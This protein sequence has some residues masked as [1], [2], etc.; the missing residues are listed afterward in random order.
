[1]DKII[2]THLHPDIDALTSI[3]LI[4]RFLPDWS[5]AKVQLVPPGETF[6]GAPPDDDPDVLH[7]D[8]GMGKLDHHKKR[9][10]TSA[11]ELTLKY[12]L[13][14]RDIRKLDKQALK[15]M[16]KVVN[17]IDNG[18]D[19]GWPDASSDHYE[20]MFH[21]L[22]LSSHQSQAEERDFALYL[23]ILDRVFQLMKSKVQ[24]EK[25]LA[26]KGIIFETKWGKG[27][28]V[29]SPNDQ[30]IYVGQ[31]QGYSLVVKQEPKYNRVK[32]YGRFDKG[33]D[34]RKVFS[35]LKKKDQGSNWYL[36]PSRSLILH[37]SRAVPGQTVTNLTLEEV[38]D[39]LK[40]A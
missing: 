40:K 15:R 6:R 31:K 35:A 30:V 16:V 38:I 1:M 22:L 3:W 28:A 11:A 20:F 4:K 33:V 5:E 26:E 10:H 17:E 25:T 21:N 39:I 37:K 18:Q 19:I 32:I 7:V 8:T 36:H 14:G 23:E 27:I 29:S 13:K 34:L 2:V 24:A 12:V 9:N